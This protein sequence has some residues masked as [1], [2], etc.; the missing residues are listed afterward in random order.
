MPQPVVVQA[1]PAQKYASYVDE[2]GVEQLEAPQE[3]PQELPLRQ[4]AALLPS[5]VHTLLVAPSQVLY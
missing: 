4:L 3:L 5:L 1:S 2:R